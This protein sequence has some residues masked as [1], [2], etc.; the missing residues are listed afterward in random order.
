MINQMNCLKKSKKRL[1]SYLFTLLLLLLP[2]SSVLGKTGEDHS[3]DMLAVLGLYSQNDFFLTDDNQNKIQPLFS[4]INNYIDE[5]NVV[6]SEGVTDNFYDKLKDEFPFFTYEK[7]YTHRQIY[8]WGFDLDNDLT[9]EDIPSDNQI[10]E[11][12]KKTFSEKFQ[13]MYGDTNWI[14]SEWYRFLKFLRAEQEKRNDA[15]IR[16]TK[17]SLGLTFNKDAR[18]IT[19]ILYYTHLLGDHIKHS[20]AYSGEAILE[21]KKIVKNVNMHIKSL[22]RSQQKEFYDR[23]L[24]NVRKIHHFTDDQYAQDILN[25]LKLYVPQILRSQFEKDFSKKGLRFC[26]EKELHNAA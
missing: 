6:N 11:T 25:M 13:Y 19:A 23:Y 17:K 1:N 26:T 22:T 2:I 5:L 8:H 4:K 15:L 18:D 9:Q 7:K 3:L 10:P 14:E 21:V 20:G 24:N 16:Y 12:L